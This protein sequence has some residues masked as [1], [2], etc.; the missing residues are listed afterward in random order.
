ML[1]VS[2]L[3]VAYGQEENHE[4]QLELLAAEENNNRWVDAGSIDGQKR[5]NINSITEEELQSLQLLHVFQIK[6]F[7]QYRQRFGDLISLMELQAIPSWDIITIRKLMPHL[8][9]SLEKPLAPE[10]TQR[11]KEGKHHMLFRMGNHSSQ[12]G[13]FWMRTNQLF[14]YRFSFNNL[15]QLGVTAEKD[16]GEQRFPDHL[17][18]YA[19]LRNKG[20]IKN[21]LIGDFTVNMGQGLLH[22]Q[23]YALGQSSNIISGFRQTLLFKPHTGTDENRY[24]RGIGISLE[25]KRWEYSAFASLQKIDAS[26]SSDSSGFT[27]WI[28]SMPVSGLHRTESEWRG[29]KSLTWF[30][31]GGRIK[32]SSAKGSLAFN[33]IRHFFEFPIQKRWVPYNAFSQRGK[34]FPMASIDHTLFTGF[35]FFY[36]ELAMQQDLSIAVLQG[37]MKSLDTKLDLSVSGRWINRKY[38]TFQSNSLTSSGEAEGENGVAVILNYH[39]HPRHQLELFVDRSRRDGITYTTDG[40]QYGITHGLLFKWIPN[41]KTEYYIRWG[42]STRNKNLSKEDEKTNALPWEISDHWRSHFS[43]SLNRS[44]TLR[45]RNEWSRTG[46]VYQSTETGFLH[47]T[48]AIYKPMLSAFSFSI[49][50]TWYETGGY[51]SRIYA[52]ERDL[53]GYYS[54]PSHAGKGSRYYLMM[55][56]KWKRLTMSG[57][58]IYIQ[59]SGSGQW[60][61]RSQILWDL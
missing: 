23:G 6:E 54:V 35:G 61:W 49:R 1:L 40:I 16:A 31:T 60:Q 45:I 50:G 13:P 20:I 56:Y 22:W 41:K 33:F 27:K 37:W 18:A 47:Y 39:P 57:K 17:S 21:L 32:Y 24:H 29:R 25:K 9:V 44:W 15:L 4:L 46:N 3:C 51:A 43:S 7:I 11:L 59:N 2:R 26:I 55:Q 5:Y 19:A 36:G 48:E 30:S 8:Y 52:Y 12:Q 14:S 38:A 58:I 53:Y 10:I 28:T 42:H 34:I